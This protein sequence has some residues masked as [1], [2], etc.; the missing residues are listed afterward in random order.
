MAPQRQIAAMA[1]LSRKQP[2]RATQDKDSTS[3]PASQTINKAI[4]KKSSKKY[5]RKKLG[6]KNT[7]AKKSVAKK[8]EKSR[9]EATARKKFLKVNDGVHTKNGITTR[10]ESN[11]DPKFALF[12]ELPLELR[13]RVWGYAA[14]EPQ[15][16]VQR[17]SEKNNSRFT[18]RR[19]V[20]SVLHACRESRLEYLEAKREEDQASADRRRQSHPLYKLCFQTKKVRCSPAYYSNDI[21]MFYG[22]EDPGTMGNHGP[23]WRRQY[24]TV[25]YNGMTELNISPSLKHLVIEIGEFRL[26]G[27][28]LALY[29]Y[30]GF[31]KLETL[32]CLVKPYVGLYQYIWRQPLTYI[33]PE[34]DG[35]MDM[36]NL[37]DPHRQEYILR[38]EMVIASFEKMCSL[39]YPNWTPP[40]LKFRF[41]DQF[42]Q[43]TNYTH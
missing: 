21:D 24:F 42:K 8:D 37:R 11:E 40:V 18:Y 36:D 43:A 23:W 17:R 32:T 15:L 1:P 9:A 34:I 26:D 28:V 27:E 29:I 2:P 31:P 19:K 16:I 13:L 25:K 4:R 39:H 20:P 30:N 6:T 10:A 12:P 35:V 22:T 41:W 14:P 5:A 7:P 38:K 3:I 33:P